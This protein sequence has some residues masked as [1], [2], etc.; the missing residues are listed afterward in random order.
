MGVTRSG[1]LSAP[2]AL[3]SLRRE[4]R[5]AWVIV[6]VLRGE[7]VVEVEVVCVLRSASCSLLCSLFKR[8]AEGGEAQV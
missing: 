2:R 8:D 6:L 5:P 1:F 7:V 4:H 3:C